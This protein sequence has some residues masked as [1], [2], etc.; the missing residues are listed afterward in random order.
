[1]AKI[2]VVETVYF[3]VGA[4]EPDSIDS[5]FSTEFEDPEEGIYTRRYNISEKIVSLDHGWTNPSKIG[6][7][8]LKNLEGEFNKLPT[9]PDQKYKDEIAKKVIELSLVS[10]EVVCLL[11]NLESCRFPPFDLSQF[12]VRSLSGKCKIEINLIPRG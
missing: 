1:M 8:V 10:G 5:R 4:E 6:Q 9:I 2:T 3:R 7:M 12:R 11:G